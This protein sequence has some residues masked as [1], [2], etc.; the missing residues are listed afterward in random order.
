MHKIFS[1]LKV[2]QNNEFSSC[3]HNKLSEVKY[4]LYESKLK[5]ALVG[6]KWS[7]TECILIT[8]QRINSETSKAVTAETPELERNSGVKY[9]KNVFENPFNDYIWLS[10][11]G[12]MF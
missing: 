4:V 1:V 8:L 2:I 6:G 10:E 12:K 5:Y 7:E 11:C 3:F 9:L